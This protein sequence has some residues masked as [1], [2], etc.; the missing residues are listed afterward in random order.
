M[1]SSLYVFQLNFYFQ[2]RGL[3]DEWLDLSWKTKCTKSALKLCCLL[4]IAID[5]GNYS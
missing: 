1:F 4:K 3:I 2:E 5:L